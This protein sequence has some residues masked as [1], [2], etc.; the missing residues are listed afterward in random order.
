VFDHKAVY[1]SFKPVLNSGIIRPTI[2]HSILRDP[3]LDL[4]VALA[5]ADT[6]LASTSLRNVNV[7]IEQLKI[8]TGQAFASIRRAGPSD[9]HINPGDRTE[10]ESLVREGILGEV[11]EFLEFFPYTP[12]RDGP[13][14]IEDDIFM[15]GL[16]NN[17]RNQVI[18]H[19][20]FMLKTAKSN[21][22]RLL[23]RIKN[24]QQDPLQNFDELTELENFLNK[25][26]DR[27]LRHELEKMSGFEAINSEKITPYFLGLAKSSKSEAKM[28]DLKNEA[29]EHG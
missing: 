16:M 11:R 3:D 27:E 25:A 22:K 15:E 7:N 6:Y 18:S 14:N 17:V 19:Q 26:F 1:L 12:L 8:G 28:A 10:A 4:V 23:E 21:R 13:L 9:I 5:V 24:L 20:A 29:G 2:S